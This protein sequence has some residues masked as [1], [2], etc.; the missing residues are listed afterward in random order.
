MM[1]HCTA[2][3]F[4]PTPPGA[5]NETKPTVR[6]WAFGAYKLINVRALRRRGGLRL[7]VLSTNRLNDQTVANRLGADLD[8]HDASVH[9]RPHFLD[10]GLELARGNAGHLRPHAA[11]VLGLTAVGD[12]VAEGRFL[13]GKMANAWHRSNLSVSHFPAQNRAEQ[14]RRSGT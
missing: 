5:P 14:S 4:C 10:I 6:P 12:L 1:P 11:E 3:Y 13:T 8:P 2:P 9:H 7:S